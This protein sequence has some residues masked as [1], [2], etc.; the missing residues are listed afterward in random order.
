MS[1][2]MANLDMALKSSTALVRIV[3]C[4][5]ES[6]SFALAGTPA[7]KN[8]QVAL[9]CCMETIGEL[10]AAREYL[11]RRENEGSDGT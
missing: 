2:G 4:A 5:L 6:D 1:D 8:I 7:W 3:M 11:Q 10:H 9:R